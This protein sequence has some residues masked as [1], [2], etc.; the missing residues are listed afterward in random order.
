MI[1][2]GYT[3]ILPKSVPSP[4]P[5]HVNY[6]VTARDL[7]DGVVKAWIVVRPLKINMKFLEYL[8]TQFVATDTDRGIVVYNEGVTSSALKTCKTFPFKVEMIHHKRLRYNLLDHRLVPLHTKV[9]HRDHNNDKL[10]EMCQNDA[11]ASYMGYETG[12]I[13]RIDRQDGTIYY[14]YV[15]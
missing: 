11:V 6:I 13:I 2:R 9:G 8:F 7:N 14:R 12:D 10:P 1:A 15:V 4:E 3:H 5:E